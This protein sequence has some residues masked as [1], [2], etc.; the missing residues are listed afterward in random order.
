MTVRVGINGFGRIGRSVF[1][2][3]NDRD[4]IEVVGIN[5]LFEN[6]Q[7]AYLLKYDT[8]MGVFDER[9]S[10]DEETLYVGDREIRMTAERDPSQAPWGE[11]G[12]D[13]VVESTG[14]FRE[15]ERLELHLAAGARRV[16]LTVPPKDEVDAMVVIGVN[17]G[18]LEP[19]HR[20]V[21]NASCTT[22]C[23]APLAKIL[24][25]AFGIEE[26]LM[27]TVHAY[28]ND[29]RLA[30]VAH[31]S[32]RR[33]RAAAVNVIPTTTGAARAVGKVLPHLDGKLDGMAIRVPVP[34]GSIVDL[35]V[36]LRQ[37]PS[38]AEINDAVRAAA[39]GPMNQVVQYSEDP[40]VSSDIIG[41]PHSSIFDAPSTA[42]EGNGF[43]NVISWYDNEWGYS[44]RVVDLIALLAKLD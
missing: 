21:S 35:S 44:N 22:N 23:L 16:V 34:D 3:L 36:R 33:S 8:V 42:T 31:K 20:I 9:V 30:D 7:L 5:D 13:V 2:I 32:L 43:A 29:Q 24:D 12:V 37:R 27:T 15:R 18:A 4:D 41:N 6:E 26:G 17:E 39:A 11:L 14:V 38:V 28:T 40:L 19:S 25:D 1:R 10:V